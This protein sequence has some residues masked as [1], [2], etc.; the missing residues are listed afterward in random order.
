[1]VHR[2]EVEVVFFDPECALVIIQTNQDLEFI[3]SSS[4]LDGFLVEDIVTRPH[5]DLPVPG[6]IGLVLAQG[7]RATFEPGQT[8]TLI[9]SSSSGA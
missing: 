9:S 8:A 2:V 5:L 7:D 3:D 6:H 1:M 4:R